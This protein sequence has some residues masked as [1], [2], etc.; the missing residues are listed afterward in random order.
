MEMVKSRELFKKHTTIYHLM[1]YNILCYVTPELGRILKIIKNIQSSLQE[2]LIHHTD[3]ILAFQIFLS[4]PF[5]VSF[6]KQLL[7]L[8]L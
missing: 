2:Y 4:K 3:S 1:Q 7:M 5:T 6:T 8:H